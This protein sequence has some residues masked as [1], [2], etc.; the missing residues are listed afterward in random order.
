MIISLNRIGLIV[1]DI[2][3]DGAAENRSTIKSMSTHRSSQMND[4]NKKIK[5]AIQNDQTF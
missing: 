4:V 2:V 5:Y 3:C 1:V